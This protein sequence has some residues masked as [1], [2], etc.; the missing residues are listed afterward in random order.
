VITEVKLMRSKIRT[1]NAVVRFAIGLLVI[2][3]IAGADAYMTNYRVGRVRS[4]HPTISALIARGAEQSPTVK[5]MVE[6]II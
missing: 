2:P 1:H 4:S 6:A 3:Q 5:K